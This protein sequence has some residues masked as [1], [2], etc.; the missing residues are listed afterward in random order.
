M[1][2]PLAILALLSVTG[3]WIG[4]S[5]FGAYLAPSVGAHEAEGGS[6]QL[7]IV[8][9]ILA[10]AVP[11]LAGSSLTASIANGPKAPASSPHPCPAGYKLLANKY[12]VDEI[13][14]A[15]IVKPLLA[16]S[17]YVLEWVVDVA[18]LG[19]IAWLLGGIA[20]FSAA[21]ILQRW[22]SGNLRS[23]AAWLALGAAALLLFV[24]V[25][26]HVRRFWNRHQTG[27]ALTDDIYQRV[28]S[29]A[30]SA[31]SARRSDSR[32]IAS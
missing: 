17:K 20:T 30:D 2:G 23:Y 8:L 15:A 12:Y 24:L 11:Q 27:G 10:V 25:P 22:Q 3:G 28:D 16:L 6:H 1:L 14:G 4:M 9:S 7:E 32:R 26:T 21:P 19:G 5:R 31:G 18:I 13:Y 29:H